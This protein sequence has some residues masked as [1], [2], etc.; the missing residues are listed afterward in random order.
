MLMKNINDTLAAKIRAL[1]RD[2]KTG[3]VSLDQI[4]PAEKIALLQAS[5][6]AA[7]IN[8]QI[9]GA[10]SEAG[11]V[12]RMVGLAKKSGAN[13][14]AILAKGGDM[15]VSPAK[16]AGQIFERKGVSV[17]EQL[18]ALINVVEENPVSYTHLTLP[19]ILLV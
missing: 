16:A 4:D 15:T 13:M 1:P 19:T 3:L 8:I 7:A 5:H 10:E 2:P 17:D 12:L 14:E 11:R 6:I 18:S 9:R